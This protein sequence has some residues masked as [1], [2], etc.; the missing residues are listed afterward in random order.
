MESL[1]G[2]GVMARS[3]RED[4]YESSWT[5]LSVQDILAAI[6]ALAALCG[7]LV[8]WGARITAAELTIDYLRRDDAALAAQII[9]L[10]ADIEAHKLQNSAHFTADDNRFVD[11]GT[12][13]GINTK[14]LD[15]I[16]RKVGIHETFI[17]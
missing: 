14:R 11:M 5:N 16:E 10:R 6:G 3:R 9:T 1:A 17:R 12:Q 2:L 13:I 8:W 15:A 7:W 4:D